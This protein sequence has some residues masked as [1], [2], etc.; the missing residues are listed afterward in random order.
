[1]VRTIEH[2]RIAVDDPRIRE[3]GRARHRDLR[4]H[5][6]VEIAPEGRRPSNATST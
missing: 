6:Y 4:G 1:V 5:C 3:T 2:Q